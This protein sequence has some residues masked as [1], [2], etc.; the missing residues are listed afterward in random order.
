MKDFMEN[1]SEEQALNVE[2]KNPLSK[3]VFSEKGGKADGLGSEENGEKDV[4]ISNE[5]LE[6]YK[7]FQE[8]EFKDLTEGEGLG[9]EGNLASKRW[10]KMKKEEEERK[11]KNKDLFKKVKAKP[12]W[13]T[14]D[15]SKL[16]SN[17]F[18]NNQPNKDLVQ[19]WAMDFGVEDS[20]L[21]SKSKDGGLLP[22]EDK[23]KI[24]HMRAIDASMK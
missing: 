24:E 8:A 13:A 22:G 19:G 5:T 23:E 14:F 7:K 20:T 9:N 3:V 1:L 16:N 2:K 15:R 21:Q 12:A 6:N 18:T 17:F 4:P 10:E 11:K